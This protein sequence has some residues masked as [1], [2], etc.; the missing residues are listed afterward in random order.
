MARDETV[1]KL[2]RRRL[3]LGQRWRL[4][5]WMPRPSPD[6]PSHQPTY[7]VRYGTEYGTVLE[8][9]TGTVD[10]QYPSCLRLYQIG[11]TE[12]TIKSHDKVYA[13]TLVFGT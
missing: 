13:K 12:F 11:S 7:T 4:Q 10:P 1:M 3:V 2:Q 9:L 6:S 5:G 8:V